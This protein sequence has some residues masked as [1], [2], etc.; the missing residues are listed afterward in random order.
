MN[1]E[2]LKPC[3][4]CQGEAKVYVGFMGLL[5][6]RCDECGAIVSFDNSYCN[7]EPQKAIEY[8]NRRI[9]NETN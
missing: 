2:K 4:F 6:V 3:P 1:N 9:E 7:K 8:W 5:Y